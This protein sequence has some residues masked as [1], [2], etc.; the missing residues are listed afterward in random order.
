MR[1]LTIFL[2]L[3]WAPATMGQGLDPRALL[4]PPTSTWPTY[5]G[6]YTGRRYSSLS[7]INQ[8]NV[9]SLTLAWAFQTHQQAMKSTPLEVNGILY[10]TV[11]N[12]V[13][14]VDAR[15][16]REI[17]HFE[18]QSGGNFI[19]NRGVAMY[20]DRLFFGTP[21]AHLICLD[22]RTGRKI[23]EVVVADTTFGYYISMAPLVVKGRLIVGISGDQT[24]VK[25]FLDCRSPI[26]GH[27]IWRW[28]STPS[29]GQP[30]ANTWPNADAM[31][32]GGGTTWMPGTYDPELN[33]IY[34]GTGN[35]HPVMSGQVR[36][37]A[38]LYTCSIVA[39]NPDTGKMVWYFQASPHDT[40]DRDANE[41]PII[42]D[43]NF[44][45]KPR[46][47]LAQASRNGYFFLLDRATGKDFLSVPYGPENWSLGLNRRG[48]PIPNLKKQPQPSG[49]LLEDLGTNWWAPSFDPETGLFYVNAFRRAFVAYLTRNGSKATQ[50]DHQGAVVSRL[51]SQ[52]QLLAIDYQT[53]KIKWDHK[54]PA[55]IEYG[56]NGSGILTTAG[57][58]LI[59]GDISGD[60]IV[61]DPATGKTLWHVYAG[62]RLTGC[63]MT[64]ELN[65]R[66]YLLT[67]VDSVLYA[68]ALPT[69]FEPSPAPNRVN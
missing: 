32:H 14:A 30:G 37:G 36:P 17:W 19:A 66:Q 63:P 58:L 24:D 65:G 10:L 2:L 27:L 20:K 60:L 55:A 56:Q 50:S 41:T 18:R 59:T 13:W 67:P 23:W 69:D 68:W 28:Y 29:P 46:K 33:L 8:S 57:H 47:L 54:S 45:G 31:A 61:L 42:F 38:N 64:Y 11:P 5:N 40:Q 34:W 26:D 39:I 1:K 48:E 52:A 16:G 44:D 25:A 53:G 22:A 43:A 7:E 49:T 9:R 4:K 62:G 12:Q 21:D 51:W 15:T 6:D 35:P 3:L